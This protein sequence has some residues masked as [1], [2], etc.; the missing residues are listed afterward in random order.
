MDVPQTTPGFVPRKVEEDELP[1]DPK[2]LAPKNRA[3]QAPEI[4]LEAELS[5]AAAIAH[6]QDEEDAHLKSD[7]PTEDEIAEAGSDPDGPLDSGDVDSDQE[8][9]PAF[10]FEE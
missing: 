2:T 7:E 4:D 3:V 9:Q 5:S 6:P 1:F 10:N 8:L